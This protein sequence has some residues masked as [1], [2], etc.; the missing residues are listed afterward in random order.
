ML[1]V[2]PG[3]SLHLLFLSHSWWCSG[4]HT[5]LGPAPESASCNT[6]SRPLSLIQ[7]HL[8]VRYTSAFSGLCLEPTF[9]CGFRQP[10]QSPLV[11]GFWLLPP[12]QGR[13]GSH[14][15]MHTTS[16]RVPLFAPLWV[17]RLCLASTVS[18]MR[19]ARTRSDLFP[20][21]L[22]GC[23]KR[24]SCW[25]GSGHEAASRSREINTSPCLLTFLPNASL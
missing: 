8:L 25:Q 22:R 2:K 3:K 4:N 14:S 6:V 5:V 24:D 17:E 10:L 21:V 7:Q 11:L 23:T 15:P 1:G 16:R 20:S 9:L 19:V 13:S 18:S 12:V